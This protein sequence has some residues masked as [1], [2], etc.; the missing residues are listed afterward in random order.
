MKQ[1]SKKQNSNLLHYVTKENGTEPAFHNEYWNHHE[2]GLYV[3]PYSG[4]VLFA[5]IHKYNSGSGWPS[6]YKAIHE[7]ELEL[8]EDFSLGMKRVEVRSRSSDSHLG[9]LFDDGPPQ[10]GKRYCIN[11]AALRFIAVEDIKNIKEKDYSAYIPLFD[12]NPHQRL[13][14]NHPLFATAIFAGGCFW[15][16]ESAFE[17]LAGVMKALN[18]YIGG[19]V[20]NPSYEQVSSGTTG[21]YE[22][23]MILY[24]PSVISYPSLL[25]IFWQQ[26]DPTDSGG[27]FYDR[28]SQYRTAIFYQNEEELQL[29]KQSIL[30]LNSSKTFKNKKI[31]TQ[32][33]P[34]TSFYLAEEYHQDYFAKE[35]QRY[36]SY[37]RASGRESFL[38]PMG[39]R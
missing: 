28:G 30:H 36:K 32:I 6:F 2:P 17:G 3:D 24:Q 5:S 37:V 13:G 33:I 35:S 39:K 7:S 15:C 23:V 8:K 11:S 25:N 18:G 34:E 14:L 4:R 16:I 1:S 20:E 27:Q 10:S 9:H 38:S 12:D 31:V 19:A 22:A 29:I 26:I 21:H